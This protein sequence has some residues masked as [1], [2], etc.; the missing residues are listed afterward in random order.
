MEISVMQNRTIQPNENFKKR[1]VLSVAP[2]IQQEKNQQGDGPPNQRRVEEQGAGSDGSQED[3]S[4]RGGSYVKW[5]GVSL[6]VIAVAML[7]TGGKSPCNYTAHEWG[8]FTSVQ[9]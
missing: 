9:G 6:A 7:A 1:Q 2:L 8:T 4:S 5:I 3:S